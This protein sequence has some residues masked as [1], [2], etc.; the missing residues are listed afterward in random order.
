MSKST[1]V[2]SYRR[3]TVEGA[4]TRL[5]PEE[6]VDTGIKFNFYDKYGTKS[7]EQDAYAVSVFENR[8]QVFKIPLNNRKRI[9]DPNEENGRVSFKNPNYSGVRENVFRF[10][11]VTEKAFKHYI[12]YL[13][14]RVKSDLKLA[15]REII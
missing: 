3:N 1:K 12:N 14:N 13:K 6:K 9:L 8:N 7:N 11:E 10:K 4:I 15:Q 5:K 2:K